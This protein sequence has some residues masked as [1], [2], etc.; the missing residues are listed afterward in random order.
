MPIIISAPHAQTKITD[1]KMR[2]RFALSDYQIWKCSDPFTSKLKQFNCAK[3]IQIAK[4]H[5][6]VCDFNR[7]PNEKAFHDKDFFGNKVFK[8]GEQF[9]KKEQKENLEKY[10]HPY[11]NKL[12]KKIL[13]LD[14]KTK[15]KATL[16]I[17]FHNT[18][19][20]HPLTKQHQYMPSIVISNLG[21]QN[22][23]RS[24]KN[25][26]SISAKN[27]Q[28]FQNSIKQHL[29]LSVE[30]NEIFHG[31]YNTLWFHELSHELKTKTKIYA[32][33]LEY[34]L[35]HVFNPLSKRLDNK[36]LRTLHQG[37]NKAIQELF[38]KLNK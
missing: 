3:Y 1:K 34:N 13:K 27:L 21:K 5:R 20:D 10:W 32:L 18:S 26:T 12:K 4:T 2:K 29:P 30:I 36:A 17:D 25:H 11:H 19:G 37:L 8:K 22:T 16:I 9:K 31:G 23:G 35:D 33:Q 38:E 28:F 14:S 6:L 24:N 15:D 7:P